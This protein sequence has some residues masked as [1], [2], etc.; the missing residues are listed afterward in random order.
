MTSQQRMQKAMAL[1]CPDRVPVM[2][3]LALGHYFLRAGI[4]PL[5]IW[6]TS[7]GFADALIKLQRRYDF[8]G[9]LINLPGRDPNF[10][11]FIDKIQRG[12]SESSIRWKNGNYTVFP[13]DDNPH[14]Y[15]TDGTRY[16]PT[17]QEIKPEEL[18]YVEPWDLTDIT[19]PF[20]WGFETEPRPFDD[21]FPEYHFDTI[22]LVKA[23]VGNT[24]SV[25][26][27]IF[28]PWSQFLELLNY[29]YALMAILDDPGKAKACLDRLAD[30]AID[31]AKKQA[32]CGVDAV[33]ISSAFAGAGLISRQHYEE[34][35]LP[36]EQKIIGEVKK[37]FPTLPVYT[38]TCGSIGDRLDLMMATGTNGIDTLD[39]PPLGTVELEEAKKIL[40]GKTFIKG[41]IDP[42]NTLLY[43]GVGEVKEDVKKRLAIGK[44]GG[45]YILS[46]ACSVAPHTPPENIEMLAHLAEEFGR[47]ESL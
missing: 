19:Y 3:Q 27:E 37:A 5:E 39:P 22:K 38:H 28:S 9:I 43:G 20:T 11:N 10:E 25:H 47:Y 21:Y 46:S 16:F 17:F 34:F 32:A 42:V 12:Q 35:V 4:K 30:G 41:N 26:S 24:V 36:Y 18:Y 13:N 8:D 29:E 1:E 31:L 33:L 40:A 45:G 14:Y 23:K 15:Q 6:Y 2:C 44:P 7:Q